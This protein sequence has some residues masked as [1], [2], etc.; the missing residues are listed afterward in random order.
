MIPTQITIEGFLCYQQKQV[1]DLTG[2]DLCMLS[3]PNGSGKSSVFDAVTVVLFNTHRAGKYGR[4]D[5]INKKCDKAVVE[6]EFELHGARFLAKRTLSRSGNG[7]QVIRRWVTAKNDW[8]IVPDTSSS[9]AYTEWVQQHVG[10]SAE[11]FTSSMLL[12]QGQ[13]DRLLVAKPAERAELLGTVVGL[14]QYRLLHE[15]AADGRRTRKAQ[16]DAQAAQ[17]A[18]M[19]QVSDEQLAEKTLAVESAKAQTAQADALIERLQPL[20]ERCKSWVELE[21]DR[22][23]SGVELEALAGLLSRAAALENDAKRLRELENV[24]PKLRNLLEVRAQR[25]SADAALKNLQTSQAQSTAAQA[26]LAEQI[27]STRDTLAAAVASAQTRLD[28]ERTVATRMAALS[29]ILSQADAIA[30][31]QRELESLKAERNKL[32]LH[33]DKDLDAARAELTQLTDLNDASPWLKQLF[34]HRQTIVEEDARLRDHRQTIEAGKA[35]L[36]KVTT[37]LETAAR[38]QAAAETAHGQAQ[39][40]EAQALAE[41]NRARKDI[42]A[43]DK[44]NGQAAC[45]TCGHVLTAEHLLTERTRRQAAEKTAIDARA[46]AAKDIRT[47]TDVLNESRARRSEVETRRTQL[48]K[49]IQDAIRDVRAVGDAIHKAVKGCGEA[50]R[51][52]TQAFRDRV[53]LIP[54]NADIRTPATWIAT[55]WP[56]PGDL[57]NIKTDVAQLAEAKSR[58]AAAETLWAK[59]NTIRVK[60]E[61]L[62]KSLA[63]QPEL[64]DVDSSRAEQAR[65]TTEKATLQTAITADRARVAELNGQLDG[66]QSKA[67]TLTTDLAKLGNEIAAAEARIEGFDTAVAKGAAELPQPWNATAVDQPLVDQLQQELQQLK[68]AGTEEAEKQLKEAQARSQQ[69]ATRLEVLRKQIDAIPAEARQ[70]PSTI[71]GQLDTTRAQRQALQHTSEQAAAALAS[72]QSAKQQRDACDARYKQLDREHQHYALLSELLG[73]EGLQRHLMRQAEQAIVNY[74]NAILDPISNGDL[75]L[76]LRG[77]AHGNGESGDGHGDGATVN[78][79]DD[80]VLDLVACH[81]R[82]FPN[83]TTPVSFLSGSQQFRVAVALALAIGQYAGGGS[84]LG[85]C[86][87]IDEGF[88]SLDAQGQDVMIEELQRLKGIMKRIILVSHQESFANAF[89][90]G[91]RFSIQEG[92]TRVDRV[93]A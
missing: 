74:A 38:D 25:T 62:T 10:V 81:N 51:A 93:S 22:H 18:A 14:D 1:I 32:G 42:L 49:R 3:G 41:L 13:A 66:L 77:H 2:M 11:T 73:R 60:I 8:E 84:R 68:A 83:D 86:V 58:A 35:E 78:D 82:I 16:L 5:L 54:E 15:R 20:L 27:A 28:E 17:L 59:W 36:A 34:G 55:T 46:A 40:L 63:S 33:P 50:Y 61:M 87:I 43:L 21:K 9:K 91:Y 69:I 88:G 29:A 56:S 23:A 67:S 71:Q 53:G 37:E 30:V 7:T 48:D 45:P 4:E 80:N 39:V 44:A 31:Q 90:S 64:A 26:T 76:R 75:R 85:E 79:D 19:P 6:L 12:R 47:A 92:E 65:L 70:Q 24:L 89:P 72:L 57:A 52:L